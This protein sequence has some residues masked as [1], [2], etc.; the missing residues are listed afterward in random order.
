MRVLQVRFKFKVPRAELEKSILEVAPKFRPGGEV[1][2][3]LWKIWLINES[4]SLLSGIYLFKD[5]A[6]V[7]TYLRGELFSAL[8][9]N[10]T[11]SDLEVKIFEILREPTKIT[12][13]PI[14]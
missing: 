3:L 2:G 12:H 6:S 13:G 5:E 11:I 7:E 14:E 8:K 1:Q 9:K 4:E 10:P